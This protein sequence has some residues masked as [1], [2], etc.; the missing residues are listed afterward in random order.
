MPFNPEKASGLV[1]VPV[2]VSYLEVTQVALVHLVFGYKLFL[3]DILRTQ[4]HL[5]DS[6]RYFSTVG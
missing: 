4:T 5:L 1:P 2:P 3:P 6:T